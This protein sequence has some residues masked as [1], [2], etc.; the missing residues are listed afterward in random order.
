MEKKYITRTDTLIIAELSQAPYNDVAILDYSLL[1]QT[2][3]PAFRSKYYGPI[4]TCGELSQLLNKEE[5]GHAQCLEVG[6]SHN[7]RWASVLTEDRW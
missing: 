4:K 1:A 2:F 6:R 7:G 3:G 5:F